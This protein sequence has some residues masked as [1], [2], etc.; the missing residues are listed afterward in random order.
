VTSAEVSCSFARSA[1]KEKAGMV[2]SIRGLTRGWQAIQ[3][4]PLTTR[5]M[6]KRFCG[7]VPSR[8]GV[9]SSVLYLY[10]E[11][12]NAN[13]HYFRKKVALACTTVD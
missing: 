7:E 12:E 13:E 10:L 9:I 11:H 1:G 2:H 3:C 5:A 6:P 4:D 8:R